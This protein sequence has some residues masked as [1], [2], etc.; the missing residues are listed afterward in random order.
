MKKKLEADCIQLPDGKK[1]DA[2]LHEEMLANEQANKVA[3]EAA[4]R[5]AIKLG[6]TPEEAREMC[7]G[8]K[9]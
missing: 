4:V 6:F 1:I 3:D 8:R 5:Q 7:G 9:K 2:P